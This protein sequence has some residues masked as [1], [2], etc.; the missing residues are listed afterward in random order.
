MSSLYVLTDQFWNREGDPRVRDFMLFTG[1]PTPMLLVMLAYLLIV[2][3]IGPAVMN[4]RRPYELRNVMLVYNILMVAV[5]AYFLY[6]FMIVINFGTRLLEL[7]A[8][9]H[10]DWSPYTLSSI[11]VVYLYYLTKFVDLL[12]TIFFVMRKK[13]SQIT[14]LHLYHHF[15]VPVLGWIVMKVEPLVPAILLFCILNT[16]VHVIMY[17]YY[18][19][20]AFGPNIQKYLWWKRYITQ[21][22]LIQ[23]VILLVYCSLTL[24]FYRGYRPVYLWLGGSQ[25][26]IFLVLFLNFYF[27][28][29][30]KCRPVKACDKH[31]TDITK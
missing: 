5:N 26:P 2:K 28:S 4:Y 20:A 10:N 9:D 27:R 24:P 3:L 7:N 18:A 6:E 29:Y 11:R 23:F 31:M 13:Y 25:P 17:S 30:N 15:S 14:V 22:Q 12:D 19:L 1:G 8:P 16:T 21:I